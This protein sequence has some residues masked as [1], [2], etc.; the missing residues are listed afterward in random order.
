MRYLIMLSLLLAAACNHGADASAGSNADATARQLPQTSRSNEPSVPEQETQDTTGMIGQDE[1][2]LGVVHTRFFEEDKAWAHF[3][4]QLDFGFRVPGTDSHRSCKGW[5]KNELEKHCE[6]VIEQTFTINLSKGPT[7]FYNLI[8]R[9]NPA[10]SR[11]IL[12]CAHWDTRPTADENPAGQQN[13]PIAGA[14]DGASG[15]AILL[16]LARVFSEH[17]P[18]DV[19]I[20]IVLFDGEDY[21]PG[22]DMMFLGAKYFAANISQEELSKYNYGI[23]LDMVGDKNLDIHPESKSES[24][25]SKI[26]STAYEMDKKLDFG[27]FKRSGEYEIY[28]DHLPLIERGM[29]I[30][31][32][33]DFNYPYWHT[34]KDTADKCSRQSLK[35]VGQIV[36]N[37]VYMH[38]DI[39]GPQ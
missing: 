7:E 13:Q 26:F 17:N 33:I 21:G 36:E 10:A 19:G 4:K 28:D 29:K 12:L 27:V 39:Y 22:L 18:P 8:G 34:T 24:V 6:K 20:D 1:F 30:Y 5:L 23:L 38:P 31:D 37:L 2:P 35:A 16:E 11:R 32:F 15:V 14:N 3:H 25:A 9:I